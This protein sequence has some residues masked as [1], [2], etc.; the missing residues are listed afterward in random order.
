MYDDPRAIRMTK[1]QAQN[2]KT[3]KNYCT[4]GGYAWSLNGRDKDNPHLYWCPQKGEHAA[5][6]KAINETN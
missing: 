2:L 4:C 6:Y 1:E 3:F 5:W